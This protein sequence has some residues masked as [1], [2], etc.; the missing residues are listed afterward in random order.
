MRIGAHL[1]AIIKGGQRRPPL[2]KKKA[3]LTLT[4]V[5]PLWLIVGFLVTV[6][7]SAGWY[8][9]TTLSGTPSRTDVQD[10]ALK[11]GQDLRISLN[12]LESGRLYSFHYS[13]T[14]NPQNQFVVQR[15]SDGSLA[16]T[17]AT[18]R[19]CYSS[20][21]DH[22]LS[23][24]GLVCGRCK[25]PMHA[26]A[27]HEKTANAGGCDLIPV[28]YELHGDLLVVK[29]SDVVDQSTKDKS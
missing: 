16:V 8:S 26:P 6:C 17:R 28:P 21:H 2:R 27:A 11:E 20:A 24:A 29:A 9:W 7:V 25:H 23:D 1:R 19:A 3:A 5:W 10:V 15:A 12:Q 22:Y 13:E 18:C 4:S 14:P